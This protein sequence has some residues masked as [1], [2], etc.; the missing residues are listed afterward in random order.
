MVHMASLLQGKAVHKIWARVPT[1]RYIARKQT[2]KNLELI[3]CMHVTF[4]KLLHRVGDNSVV[5]PR[6]RWRQQMTAVA[7]AGAQLLLPGPSLGPCGS[8][9]GVAAG[10]WIAA[11]EPAGNALSVCSLLY[12]IKSFKC[13]PA[14]RPCFLTDDIEGLLHFFP[15][16]FLGS[17]C[18]S[19]CHGWCPWHLTAVPASF[20]LFQKPI[21]CKAA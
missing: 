20:F 7:G 5:S 11:S 9:A 16:S 6:W 14:P 21:F 8:F 12:P 15:Q 4:K 17:P 19:S 3:I 18:L 2:N 1:W 13:F 10:R